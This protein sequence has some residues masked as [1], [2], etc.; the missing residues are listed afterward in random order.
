MLPPLQALQ[1]MPGQRQR[2]RQHGGACDPG[3]AGQ[4]G[5]RWHARAQQDDGVGVGVGE[6]RQDAA[7]RRAVQAVD[8]MPGPGRRLQPA[9]PRELETPCLP[10]GGAEAGQGLGVWRDE[11]HA[12]GLQRMQGCHQRAG[13]VRH[14]PAE[15]PG[16]CRQAP[17]LGLGPDDVGRPGHAHRQDADGRV[18]ELARVLLERLVVVGQAGLDGRARAGHPGDQH[19]H[20]GRPEQRALG[21]DGG[22]GLRHEQPDQP[23]R[24]I[25]GAQGRDS[26]PARVFMARPGAAAPG[27]PSAR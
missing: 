15:A 22:V 21:L 2:G 24:R 17:V 26:R 27:A 9:H 23:L 7:C 16:P 6:L 25:E 11:R 20:P 4:R 1:R 3:L 19:R 12:P 13:R 14:R 5:Q 10:V 8:R 18:G